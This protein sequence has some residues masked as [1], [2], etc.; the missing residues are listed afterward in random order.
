VTAISPPGRFGVLQ[1]EGDA[2]REIH[3]KP[4]NGETLI[5]GGFFVLEP[6]ALDFVEGDH[7]SWE[8]EPMQRLAREGQ[9]TA[10]EHRGFWQPM[11]TLREK[12][13]LEDL[14]A[15]GEAPWK[16]W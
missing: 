9:L 4:E 13:L 14:W 7:I 1:I 15:S 16:V 5:N 2:V 11:D 8:L 3:E 12:R 6:S 10:F